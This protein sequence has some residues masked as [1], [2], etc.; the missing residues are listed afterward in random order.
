M[1]ILFINPSISVESDEL[2]AT[3]LK[4]DLFGKMS[5][6]PRLAPMMLAA[7]TP[8]EYS[9]NYLDEDLED[10]NFDQID[11]DLIA[12]TGMTVQAERAYYLADKFRSMGYPVIMGGIHASSCPEETALHVDAVCI[13]EGE[14]YWPIVLED[15]AKGQ[16]KKVYRAKDYPAVTKM[17]MPKIDI[18]NHDSYSVFPIQATRGCPYSCDFCCIEI[19][20][21]RKHRRKPVAQVVAEIKALEKYNNELLRKRYHFM[22]DNLYVNREYTIELFKA[23]IPLNIQWMG[24]GSLNIIQDE[25][26]LKLVAKSGCRSFSIGFESISEESLKEANKNKTNSIEQYKVAAQKLIEHGIIPAGYFIF[27]FDHDDESSFER[28]TKFTIE[29]RIINPYFNILTPFPGTPLYKRIEDK[30]FD[31][32]WSHY[33]SLKCVYEPAK[34]SAKAL[35]AGS[36][37]ASFEVARIDIMKDHMKYFWSHGPWEKNPRLKLRDRLLLI[38]IGLKI[39]DKKESRK[40]L[41]WAALRFNATDSYQIISTA[42]FYLAAEKFLD[43]K[44]LALKE[45]ANKE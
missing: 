42:I 9:F 8:K 18:V 37:G 34:L 16:L 23:I 33:G 40:F 13:G 21:G 28:T 41:I 15:F 3:S 10:I 14:K 31:H 29:N 1:K 27:G 2:W 35:E 19:S 32:N 17:P 11:A 43:L 5:F 44:N 30:I 36:Y 22:D 26:V 38:L 45:L 25:E 12:L 4:I 6:I 24:M 7:I 39:W 20:S